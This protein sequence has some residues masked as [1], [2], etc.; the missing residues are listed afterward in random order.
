MKFRFALL[1]AALALALSISA[2][3]YS[4]E[5]AQDAAA[6]EVAAFDELPESNLWDVP[7][8]SW[9]DGDDDRMQRVAAG[10][11]S[12]PH[13]RVLD[14]LAVDRLHLH[15]LAS[16]LWPNLLGEIGIYRVSGPSQT[17]A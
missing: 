16:R 15:S 6:T 9:Q 14:R 8:T 12:D 3:A 1:V 4:E 7:G 17:A 2:F 13:V 5:P 10:E 11:S